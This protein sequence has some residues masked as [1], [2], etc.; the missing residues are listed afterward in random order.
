M[1]YEKACA[2]TIVFDEQELFAIISKGQLCNFYGQ[3]ETSVTVETCYEVD[4]GSRDSIGL[5][6]NSICKD[7]TGSTNPCNVIRCYE[8]TSINDIVS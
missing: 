1:T 5:W 4:K 3:L 6:Y 7:V 2:E 8:V